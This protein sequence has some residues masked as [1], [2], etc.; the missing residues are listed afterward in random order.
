[1]LAS[2]RAA[3]FFVAMAIV[4]W[5]RIGGPQTLTAQAPICYHLAGET[6]K[7]GTYRVTT[8]DVVEVSE[9]ITKRTLQLKNYKVGT[10][11]AA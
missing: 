2:V 9:D 7:H 10:L 8:T 4:L 11:A 1:M 3:L 5:K 6:A